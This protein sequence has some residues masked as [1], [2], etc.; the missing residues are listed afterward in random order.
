MKN[1]RSTTDQEWQVTWAANQQA[2]LV[3]T[4]SASP[5]QRLAWLEEAIEFVYRVRRF[6]ELHPPPPNLKS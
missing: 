5:A 6:R 1:E 2:Q 4:L 3:G